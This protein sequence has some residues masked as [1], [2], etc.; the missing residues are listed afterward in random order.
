M[1]EKKLLLTVFILIVGLFLQQFY[2]QNIFQ[3]QQKEVLSDKREQG[4]IPAKQYTERV[5]VQVVKVVDGDTITI[6]IDGKK[7]TVRLIGIDTPESVDPRRPVEC[8][9]KEASEK[10]KSLVLDKKVFIQGDVTQSNKDKYGRILRYVFLEDETLVN[11]LLIQE[12]YAYEYT[13]EEP[14]Q[15]QQDFKQAEREAREQQKGFWS[16]TACL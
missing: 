6:K 9:G 7:E 8:F 4:S 15:Y 1:R 11:E 14:Y 5:E 13:Y 10:T 3:E 16:E 12:G 2:G